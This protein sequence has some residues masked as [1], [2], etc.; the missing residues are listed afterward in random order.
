MVYAY[1]LWFMLVAYGLCL[2][3][4]VYACGLWFM[5]VVNAFWLADGPW[6]MVY[7]GGETRAWGG[8]ALGGH[9][10]GGGAEGG[11]GRDQPGRG[12]VVQA[13]GWVGVRDANTLPGT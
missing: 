11:E 6:P 8:G 12:L 4:T 3:L 9:L 7:G 2:W 5:L 10:A 1:G 13:L